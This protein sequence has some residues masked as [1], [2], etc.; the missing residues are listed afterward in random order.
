M[1]TTFETSPITTIPITLKWGKVIYTDK[2]LI[3]VNNFQKNNNMF[4]LHFSEEFTIQTLKKDI[5][6]L[7][8]VPQHRQKLLCKELWKGVLKDKDNSPDLLSSFKKIM[9]RSSFKSGHDGHDGCAGYEDDGKLKKI[10]VTLIGSADVLTEK[11]EDER[12]QFL[13]DMTSDEINEIEKKQRMEDMG[14]DVNNAKPS[15]G[16]IVALQIEPGEDRSTGTT[17]QVRHGVNAAQ[18]SQMIQQHSLVKGLSQSQI[19]EKLRQRIESGHPDRLKG[20]VVMTLGR[21]LRR[22]YVN[23][24]AVLNNGT[25]V[26]ALDDAHVQ[27]WRRGHLLKDIIHSGPGEGGVDQV[28]SLDINMNMNMSSHNND[29]G[30][31]FVTGGKGAIRLWNADG[32]CLTAIYMPPGTSPLSLV[33]GRVSH[34]DGGANNSAKSS[35]TNDG[36][37]GLKY[38]ATCLG[39][40]RQP[41]PNQFRLPPQDEAARQRRAEAEE[42]ENLIQL[43]LHQTSL[44]VKYWIYDGDNIQNS[45]SFHEGTI[46]PPLIFDGEGTRSYAAP[47]VAL[48]TTAKYLVCGD[49]EG[50]LRVMR[51]RGEDE[52]SRDRASFTDKSFLL[53]RST[54]TNNCRVCCMEHIRDNLLAVATDALPRSNNHGIRLFSSVKTI[55]LVN[56][57]VVSIIDLDTASLR[58]ILDAHSDIVQKICTLPN[59]GLLTAGGKMDATIRVWEPESLSR[60]FEE[61]YEESSSTDTL[62]IPTLTEANKLNEPGHVFDLK[63]LP[64]ADPCSLLYAIAAARY[65]VV[66]IVI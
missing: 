48:A 66:K 55:D 36:T 39:V 21:E 24:L 23:A 54:Q 17:S 61:T 28:V 63:V 11:S 12:P 18:R 20:E 38:I 30:S 46:H 35:A 32:D 16:D 1:T 2:I 3:Y 45:N 37:N 40:T 41:N 43:N 13:E 51:C 33:T 10:V 50:G 8:H 14:I 7:T 56:P 15:L 9:E 4:S 42:L 64:D 31:L 26:S 59:G 53:F 44:C 52:S 27:L 5:A 22:G 34:D 57:R 49:Q 25:L 62:I 58:I 6:N 47:M 60:S 19:E 65:N 29:Q